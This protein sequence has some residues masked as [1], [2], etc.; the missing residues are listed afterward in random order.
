LTARQCFLTFF[1]D[2]YPRAV[3][4]CLNDSFDELFAFYDF[5]AAHWRH[6]RTTN[7]IESTFATVR[8]RTYSTRGQGS[9]TTTLAL[10]FKLAMGAST[11]W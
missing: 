6:I 10:A 1:A 11:G 3:G 4:C 7:P 9:E 5:P 2:K 8:K